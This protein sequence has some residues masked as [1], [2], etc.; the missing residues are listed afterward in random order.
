MK[1]CKYCGTQLENQAT[2]SCEPS[3][4]AAEKTK[5]LTRLGIIGVAALL[6][7]VI[8]VTIISSVTKTDIMDFTEI[9]FEGVDTMGEA[10]VYIDYTALYE[11]I[12]GPEPDNYEEYFE[13]EEKCINLKNG[14]EYTVSKDEDLSN[15]EKIE[16]VFTFTGIA[17]DELKKC[18]ETITVSG[19]SEVEEIDVFSCIQVKFIGLNGAGYFDYEVVDN[20]D[21]ID[22]LY[23]IMIDEDANYELTNGMTVTLQVEYSESDIE[24][25]A[26]VP[27][28]RTKT[29][30]VSGLAT[31]M[32]AT[33]VTTEMIDV[34]RN[35][36]ENNQQEMIDTVYSYGSY[37]YK[38][39]TYNSAYFY[40]VKEENKD[41]YNTEN[42]NKLHVYYTADRYDDSGNFVESVCISL[43]AGGDY[44]FKDY[45][46]E[47][48]VIFED[49]TTNI[50][51]DEIETDI[52]TDAVEDVINSNTG[53]WLSDYYLAEK[54]G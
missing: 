35:Q 18:S 5:K 7:I 19:L 16:I 25:Y 39:I 54:V 3:K 48:L 53:R 51:A 23:I 47:G 11:D 30:T 10:N 27:K 40:T 1:Y 2:C 43:R 12:Y 22:N 42:P 4:M 41:D 15:D 6:V 37:T 24:R 46:Y 34:I 17:A 45:N 8:V 31:I 9:A 28:E 52:S 14:I 32:E 21:F 20:D 50:I 29:Y 49:G 26:K 38:N 36:F 44:Y 13:W 33:D